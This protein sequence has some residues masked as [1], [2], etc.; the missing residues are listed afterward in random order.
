MGGHSG[1]SNSYNSGHSGSDNSFG[2]SGPHP[3]T[4]PRF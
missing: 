4:Y 1:L 2:S 3:S